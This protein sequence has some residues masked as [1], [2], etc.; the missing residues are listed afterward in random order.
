MRRIP[1]WIA[2]APVSL[3]RARLGFLAGGRMVMVE[4]RGRRTGLSRL[5]VLEV[6]GS[7]ES[8]VDVVSGYGGA[9][10][11]YRNVLADPHVRV[12]IGRH[13]G[14]PALARPLPGP[15]TRR[16]LEAYRG[17]HPRAARTLGRLL[18]QDDL[19]T[20]SELP[21]DIGDRLPVVRIVRSGAD[22]ADPA[23]S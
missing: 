10:Q 23:G 4:H 11:W 3:F 12:W 17:R 16:V 14:A 19:R 20:G 22:G 21:E 13:A 9:A 6:V 8:G 18:D 1:R 15:E 7:T 5:V 2:R